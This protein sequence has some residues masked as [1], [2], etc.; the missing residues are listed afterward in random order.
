MKNKEAK[1]KAKLAEIV[2]RVDAFFKP[3]EELLKNQSKTHPKPIF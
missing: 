1:A 2:R 3:P